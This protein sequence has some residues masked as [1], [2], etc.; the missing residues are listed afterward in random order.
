[1]HLSFN[2][3]WSDAE[4]STISSYIH[5]A[6]RGSTYQHYSFVPSSHS[7]MNRRTLPGSCHSGR[8]DGKVSTDTR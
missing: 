1:M 6:K 7:Y 4:K 8:Y 2:A 3:V 5:V